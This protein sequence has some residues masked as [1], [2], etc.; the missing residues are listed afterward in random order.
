[1]KSKYVLV[2]A[3]FFGLSSHQLFGQEEPQEFEEISVTGAKKNKF[4][5]DSSFVVGKLPLKDLENPQVYNSIPKELIKEQNVT[6][7]NQALKN[8][9]GVTRLWESTGRG[10]DGAEYYSMRG[11]S[12]QPLMVNG[13]PSVSNGVIDPA[14]VESIQVIKGPSGTLFGSPNISYGGL[15]N[16]TTK[17][18]YDRDGGAFSYTMGNYGLNRITL[19]LNESYNEKAAVRLNGAFTNQN[20]FQDA[21]FN[22][23]Y[24]LAPSFKFKPTEKMTVLINSE[25]NFTEGAN[26]PMIFLTRNSPLAYQS[27]DLF[28][29]NYR[30]SYT[31]NDLTMSNQTFGVQGQ[32]FYEI[33][34]HWTSQTAVSSSIAETDGYYQYLWDLNDGENFIRYMSKRNGQTQTTDIQQ[35]FIGNFDIGS[36]KNKMVVGVDY[37]R[38]EVLNSSTGW[39]GNGIVNLRTQEDS[40][41]LTAMA[42][43]S[44]LVGSFE[45]QTSAVNEIASTYISNVTEILPQ[46]S[47]MLSARIDQFMSQT[48]AWTAE[49]AT[50]QLAVSPKFGIVYQPVKDKVALFANYMNGFTNVAPAQV[51]DADGSN[52]RMKNF[53]PEQANQYEAGVK[54]DIWKNKLALT[55]SYYNI[56]VSNKLMQD[57]ENVNN[58]IQGGEVVSQG[59]ELSLVASPIRGMNIV[60]GFSHN[61]AEVT[62]DNPDNG[63]LGFRPEESGPAQMANFY[64]SY[65]L[66]TTKLRGLGIGFGGNIASEH[67]TLNRE[68]SGTFTLPAYQI[69]NASLMYRVRRFDATLRINNLFNDKYYSGW[70]TINP[71]QLRGVSLKIGYRF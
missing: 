27:M 50:D 16:V 19:D 18:P 14:N 34:D 4:K 31:S 15:I 64:V 65:V 13:L 48:D 39:V 11:F 2:S 54:T 56:T 22:K 17:Q 51:A 69:F 35:N 43:D 36:M 5:E 49:G 60:A 58:Q 67:H 8:A 24:Y 21:G 44:L 3:L 63:Y 26:A 6:D 68:V 55:A 9:T 28:E 20:S 59:V 66:P 38:Q 33:N 7:F 70:S 30:N 37:Y 42:A 62:E 29:Q 52:V 41:R 32:V 25:F 45:G 10:G 61:D 1:M 57:P 23:S 46:L 53:D 47:I 12:V 71:Q 40:G